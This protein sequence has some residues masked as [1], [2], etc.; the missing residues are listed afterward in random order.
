MRHWMGGAALGMVVLTTACGGAETFALDGQVVLESANNEVGQE[1]GQEA[2]RGG[3]G[4]EDIIGGERVVVFNQDEEEVAETQLE[5]GQPEDG[6]QTCVFPFA[7]PE[8]PESEG[9]FFVI[10]G[11]D[12]V[13]YTL[14][15]LEES[16][17]AV[18][19]SLRE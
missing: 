10:G 9:Y 19:L 11:R 13:A 5:L 16:D 6:G 8:L 15:D 7:I 17:F 3:G 18:Q 14:E 1:G 2:C 12:P 4:Y